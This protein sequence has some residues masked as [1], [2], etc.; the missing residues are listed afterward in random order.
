MPTQAQA[1]S[2]QSQNI[3]LEQEQLNNFL[4][5]V[6]GALGGLPVA[7]KNQEYFVVYEGAGGTGPEIIDETAIFITYL[8]DAK[9]NISKPSQEYISLDNLIQNFEVGKNIII[10]NDIASATNSQ[11]A[12][13]QKISAI[14]RQLP[15]LYSQTGSS[16][17]ANVTE[18]NFDS[19]QNDSIIPNIL[20][21]MIRGIYDPNSSNNNTW[22]T[23]TNYN[24]PTLIPDV[25]GASFNN[26][27]GTYEI[28]SSGVTNI[29]TL[30]FEVTAQFQNAH[31]ADWD[32]SLRIRRDGNV[33]ATK[34]Y[35]IPPNNNDPLLGP[36]GN[37]FLNT[38]GDPLS[39]GQLGTILQ[40]GD[41][42]YDVQINFSNSSYTWIEADFIQFKAKTQTPEGLNSSPTIPFWE[43]NSGNNIWLTASAAISDNYGNT[44]NSQ[45]VLDEIEPGFNFSPVIT[46]F[47]PK[48][49]DRIRFG[50][51]KNNDYVIYEVTPPEEDPEGLLKLRLNTTLPPSLNL[52]NFV[53]HRVDSTDP[54]YIIVDVPKQDLVSN[55][56]LFK[57]VLLPE[58]PTKELKNNLDKIILD[59]K[60]RGIIPNGN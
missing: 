51:N 37:G 9:G 26:T 5:P 12:G 19:E 22:V 38:S 58:N 20:G 29:Q 24:F 50:Y 35:T 43:N 48:P 53:L 11:I 42:V 52:N 55:N 32:V 14:G 4:G 39:I 56:E 3:S 33:I 15:L 25:Q 45:N 13:K 57:G 7:E 10:R 6:N 23:I 8:V 1:Q 31:F 41:P 36:T 2:Q 46:P 60:E 21:T 59:L 30:Y 34:T 28:V 54:V 40:L 16:G 18:L 49:G 27:A 47:I 17:G 44:Q